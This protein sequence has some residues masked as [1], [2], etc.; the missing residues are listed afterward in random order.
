VEKGKRGKGEE[1]LLSGLAD[2]LGYP[3]ITQMFAEKGLGMKSGKG[4]KVR[5]IGG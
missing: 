4:E 3:Q 2:Y 1:G 5:D